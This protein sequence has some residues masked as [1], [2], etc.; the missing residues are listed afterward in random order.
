MT[1][2]MSII[3]KNGSLEKKIKL[4]LNI[5]KTKR[6]KLEMIPNLDHYLK[7]IKA[8]IVRDLMD[9]TIFVSWQSAEVSMLQILSLQEFRILLSTG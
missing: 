5:N 7:S 1:R 4:L 8:L 3:C 9:F 2:L 6:K